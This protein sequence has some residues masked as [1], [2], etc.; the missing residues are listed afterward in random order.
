MLD[1]PRGERVGDARMVPESAETAANWLTPQQP[2][3]APSGSVSHYPACHALPA[4]PSMLR[5]APTIGPQKEKM[6]HLECF[7]AS[8]GL[9]RGSLILGQRRIRPLS[10]ASMVG[11]V[12]EGVSPAAGGKGWD[13]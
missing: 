10:P 12:R 3:E 9:D 1:V 13:L 4:A 11:R 8:L 7:P 2:S 5:D 6:T